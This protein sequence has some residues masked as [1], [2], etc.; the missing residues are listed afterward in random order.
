[1]ELTPETFEKAEFVERRRGGYD[2]DQVEAFLEETGTEFARMLVRFQQAESR[3][4]EANERAAKT[5]TEAAE[6][7]QRL[8]AATSRLEQTER[9]LRAARSSAQADAARPVA[10]ASPTEDGGSDQDVEKVARALLIAQ[11]A[12]DAALKQAHAE[13]KSIVDSANSRSERQLAETTTKIEVL[14]NEAKAR[15]D[16]EYA[17]RREAALGE[18][19]EL[20]SRRG[21]LAE[22]VSRMEDRIAGY[23]DDLRRA[24]E[25][26]VSIA[27][28]PSL[29]GE[30][31]SPWVDESSSD[32]S[33]STS[34]SPHT[35]GSTT[36][37]AQETENSE[38]AEDAEDGQDTGRD[39]L[40]DSGG[41]SQ[42]D[43][44]V[45]AAEGSATVVSSK[46]ASEP[47]A[48]NESD[49]QLGLLDDAPETVETHAEA[50]APRESLPADEDDSDP[51]GEG[52]ASVRTLASS[53]VA[54]GEAEFLDLRAESDESVDQRS[55]EVDGDISDDERS[56]WGPGSWSKVAAS[57]DEEGASGGSA[58]TST[59]T[60]TASTSATPAA[61]PSETGDDMVDDRP[62]ESIQRIDVIRDRYLEELDQAVNTDDDP[63]DEALAAFLEGSSETKARRFGWR[64]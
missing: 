24:A 44:V 50:G 59:V 51:E 2:I 39:S 21:S 47:A 56:E 41:S 58:R 3:I 32:Q 60:T 57:L 55:T 1:M 36:S 8:S 25:E 49:G 31:P 27:D 6:L 28:D 33:V 54:E 34:S 11:D 37:S 18:V 13:A 29:M 10:S 15:A 9:E 7:R 19:S 42:S 40:P 4:A 53:D 26:L 48:S 38:N 52:S 35:D 63:H 61:K 46:P 23:R 22:V 45:S 16:R 64:R 12:A 62:T 14:V 30:R 17:R 5:E 43:R 20:E